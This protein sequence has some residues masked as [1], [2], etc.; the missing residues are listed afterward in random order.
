MDKLTGECCCCGF[1]QYHPSLTTP[2]LG[3]ISA[4]KEAS[5]QNISMHIQGCELQPNPRSC[6]LRQSSL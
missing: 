6:G 3:T 4:I 5:D 2:A 1:K